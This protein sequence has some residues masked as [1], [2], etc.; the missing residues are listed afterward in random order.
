MTEKKRYQV[1]VSSTFLDLQAAR[2]AVFDTLTRID[3]IPAGMETFPA[4]DEEQLTYIKAIIDDSDYYVLVI[5]GRYGS[6]T[7]A[8]VSY[9]ENEYDY[10]VNRGIPILSF[11]HGA[12]DSIPVG[13]TD[14]DPDKRA[15]LDAFIAKV[16]GGRIVQEWKDEN[17]LSLKVTHA[18]TAS[19]KAKPG[20]GWIRGNAAASV[21]ILTEINE[22]RKKNEEYSGMIAAL[23]ENT[24]PKIANIAPLSQTINLRFRGSGIGGNG[25]NYNIN[26]TFGKIFSLIG[27]SLIGPSLITPNLDDVI[28]KI[29]VAVIRHDQ[30]VTDM[31]VSLIHEDRDTIKVQLIS[32]G[33]V[34]IVKAGLILT[35]LGTRT[36]MELKAVREV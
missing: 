30:H 3:C 14:K 16:R 5:G 10:A 28:D 17:E 25:H 36:L 35:S 15:R 23:K 12:P 34:E 2:T 7:Q 1:F 18:V 32:Y 13:L 22:L 4:F 27:P 21:S 20:I 8:G 26:F 29:L 33:F 31:Y 19:I 9:T 11:V 24:T 6:V